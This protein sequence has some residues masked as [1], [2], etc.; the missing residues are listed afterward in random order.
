MNGE[1]GAKALPPGVGRSSLQHQAEPSVLWSFHWRR[2]RKG[3]GEGGAE[4]WVLK[5]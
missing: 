4:I 2:F 5:G 1:E 3:F